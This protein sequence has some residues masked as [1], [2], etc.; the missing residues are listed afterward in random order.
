MMPDSKEIIK[1]CRRAAGLT[2]PELSERTYITVPTLSRYETGHNVPSLEIL[3]E[4]VHACG[5]EMEVFCFR[6]DSERFDGRKRD[7]KANR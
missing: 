1:Q 6:Q 3:T 2:Q 4:I 7:A 5:F